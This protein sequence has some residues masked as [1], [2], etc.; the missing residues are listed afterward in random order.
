MQTELIGVE[1][2]SD[3]AISEVIRPALSRGAVVITD[4]YVD[5]SLAYQGAGRELDIADRPNAQ[6][7]LLR[8]FGLRDA[9]GLTSYDNQPGDITRTTFG[10][11]HPRL[12]VNSIGQHRPPATTA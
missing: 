5:S 3:G 10:A 11:T 12:T 8:Q 4:R 1:H 6:H 9:E 7:R 2:F